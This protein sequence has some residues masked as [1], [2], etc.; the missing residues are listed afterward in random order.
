MQRWTIALAMALFAAAAS[1]QMAGPPSH[2]PISNTFATA[3]E[4]VVDTVASIDL[5]AV[6]G[7]YDPQFHNL[8]TQRENLDKLASNEREQAVS[9]AIKDM[10]LTL[11]ACH[12]QAIDGADLTRCQG[13]LERDRARVM[14][15]LGRRKVNGAWT[16]ASA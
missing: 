7:T 6:Q 13:T 15:V 14:E 8:T 5:H 12:I 9:A 11:Q 2:E 3:A 10:V 16:D 1:S 4:T